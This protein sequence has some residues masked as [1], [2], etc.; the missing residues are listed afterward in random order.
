M[1]NFSGILVDIILF[2]IVAGNAVLG[3]RKGL[4]KVIFNICSSIVAIIL[5]LILYKPVTNYVINNTSVSQ[6]LE[7]IFAEN[8]ESLGVNDDT[9]NAEN[10][11]DEGLINS[12]QIFVGD[13]VGGV[14][15]EAKDA[16]VKS[17]SKQLSQK[18]IGIITF[19][20]LFAI[21]RLLLYVL[22][23]YVE[24]VANLPIIRIF[25][26][27]GGMIYGIVKGFLI[28]YVFF[29]IIS[30]VAPMINQTGIVVAIQNAQIGSKMFNNN[31]ILN[32]IFKFL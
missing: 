3:Y 28:I 5:V 15:E 22:K 16:V 21:I 30:F 11:H 23:N 18:V 2:F 1:G 14:I 31:I 27:S 32:F 12:L 4:V 20:A 8:L 6:K 25:N 19:F 24:L 7:N 10:K 29:A 17:V 26:G 13:Q 9:E